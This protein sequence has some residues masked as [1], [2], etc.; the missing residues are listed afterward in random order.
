MTKTAAAGTATQLTQRNW[1]VATGD[2]AFTGM[3]G[4]AG[5]GFP[6]EPAAPALAAALAAPVRTWPVW[7][8]PVW[9]GAVVD[10]SGGAPSAV[11]EWR[12]FSILSITPMMLR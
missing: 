3:A 11:S 4:N 12:Q 5:I 2:F 7:V 1:R 10:F 6:L 8:A 9:I